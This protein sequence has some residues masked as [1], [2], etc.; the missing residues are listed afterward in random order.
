MLADRILARAWQRSKTTHTQPE[1][2]LE[3]ALGAALETTDAWARLVWHFGWKVPAGSPRV[4]TQDVVEEG[5]SD[6]RLTFK[7]GSRVVL[8]LKAGPAPELDQMRKY[9]ADAVVI[10]IATTPRVYPSPTMVGSTT[11]GDLVRIP[12]VDPPLPWRQLVLLTHAVEVAMPVV[13]APSLTGLLASYDA[14]STFTKWSQEAADVI[15][16]A[17]SGGGATFVTREKRRGRRFDERA[18]RRQVSWAWPKPWRAHPFAGI[19]T[20]LYFGRPEAPVLAPGLPDLMLT[21]Q[22]E[23]GKVLHDTLVGDVDLR[24]A[25]LRWVARPPDGNLRVWLPGN[26][27]LIHARRTSAALLGQAEAG[28]TYLEWVG[29]I[30]SEWE[31]DGITARLRVHLATTM[32]A[33]ADDDDGPANDATTPEAP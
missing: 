29:R 13:D 23:P 26:W 19:T 22:C 1:G 8:E 5:R 4:T 25:A 7:D 31:A 12:W 24:A 27:A 3:D 30:V 28:K 20:G 16:V 33:T 11:W 32:T 10:G 18:H 6:L 17:L 9:E 21:F 2:F 14:L 15:A